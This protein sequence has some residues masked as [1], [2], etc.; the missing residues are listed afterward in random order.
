MKN[1]MME[2]EKEA[3]SAD[4]K[5]QGLI[6]KT[7]LDYD[8]ANQFLKS[9]KELQAKIKDTFGPIISKAFQAHKEAKAQET[10]HLEPLIKAESLI[11]N[12][13]LEFIREQ[14]RIRQEQK[15]NYKQR[16]RRNVRKH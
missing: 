7:Q 3:V 16:P 4:R 6:V 11:K 2:I 12:K 14:E 8:T 9:I 5:A 10:K 1:E 15:E 13:M